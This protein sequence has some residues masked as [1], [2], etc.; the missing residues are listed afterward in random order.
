M[1]YANPVR[2]TAVFRLLSSTSSA[3]V[4]V[5]GNGI[6]NHYRFAAYGAGYTMASPPANFAIGFNIERR[7]GGNINQFIY[8]AGN[9]SGVPAVGVWYTIDATI[10]GSSLSGGLYL[11]APTVPGA[12]G[13]ALVAN[14]PLL[15]SLSIIDGSLTTGGVAI[16]ADGF[17]DFDMFSVRTSCEVGGACS[18]M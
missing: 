2:V 15:A 8:L 10:T 4:V 5:R 16:Y 12:V 1:V 3:A 18:N 11:G 6:G 13:A 7:T 17:V 14:L 9:A